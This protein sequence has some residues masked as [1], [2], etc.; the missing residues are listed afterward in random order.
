MRYL[1]SIGIVSIFL[2]WLHQS[3]L[4]NGLPFPKVGCETHTTFRDSDGWQ[5]S[6]DNIAV[7]TLWQKTEDRPILEMF[8][9][10]ENSGIAVLPDR[11]IFH[12]VFWEQN[13][14]A[15]LPSCTEQE[16]VAFDLLTG[17]P[18]WRY[19]L[20]Q[21]YSRPY[22]RIHALS[23]GVVIVLDGILMKLDSEGQYVW[24]NEGFPSRSIDTIYEDSNNLYLPSKT[25]FYVVSNET[26]ELLQI[27]N[28]HLISV[29]NGNIISAVDESRIQIQL[30]GNQERFEIPIN[31][32]T[33]RN[34]D[35]VPF[36]DIVNDILLVFEQIG[37]RR[38]IEAYSLVNGQLLWMSE[39]PFEGLPVVSGDYVYAYRDLSIE[40]LEVST[41]H[42]I[43]TIDLTATGERQLNIS[44]YE[45]W[46][47][48]YDN[49]LIINIRDTWDIIALQIDA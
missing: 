3:P 12:S 25:K 35:I 42:Q 45:V 19:P 5:A 18:Q 8:N 41:G 38:S 14:D 30:V 6:S 37:F 34:A 9:G 28:T 20:S 15:V 21:E 33:I 39:D 4:G 10:A 1:V 32:P 40:I 24:S 16:I 2:I 29:L 7:R 11:V 26:G 43:G 23:D 27:T 31:D 48:S 36:T 46:I 47:A 22:R 49:I 13:P 44:P 17:D